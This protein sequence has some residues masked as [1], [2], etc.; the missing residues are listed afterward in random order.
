MLGTATPY[1]G[2]YG[3]TN[4][5]SFAS[6]LFRSYFVDRTRGKVCRLSMDGITPISSAGMHD[7]F[8]DNL[9]VST[10]GGK[11]SAIPTVMGSFDTKKQ[12]YNVTINKLTTTRKGEKFNTA[13]DG[14]SNTAYLTK[15]NTLSYSETAKG[16]VSFKSFNPENGLSINN[17]Y[18]TF[19]DGELWKHHT[20][21]TRNNFYGI[22]AASQSVTDAAGNSTDGQSYITTIL[23]DQ[24]E[25][26]KSFNVLNYEGSQAKITQHKL[27]SN[28]TDANGANV[29]QADGEYYNLNT[30][31]GW[32]VDSFETNE[33]SATIP[34]F[35]EKEGKWFN[36]I[37][38][39]ATTHVNDEVD[40]SVTSSN[41]DQQEFSVQGIGV[42]SI[43]TTSGVG[44]DKY[45]LT[46]SNQTTLNYETDGGSGGTDW[47]TTAD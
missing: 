29:S 32:Y 37:R 41:L 3:T 45:K 7:W 30:K 34:E 20:N 35:K 19:K 39:V 44:D 10:S 5:E 16:W 13:N 46:V 15:Y 23:N 11:K 43:I 14:D 18:Y 4:P 17:D 31:T 12:L 24:P 21:A 26:I 22:A 40:L 27:T 42:A 38:G 25:S 28:T 47:D 8:A 1:A 9:Q 33:Q 36:Y 2:D 6:D